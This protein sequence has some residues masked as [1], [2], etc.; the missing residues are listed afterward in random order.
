MTDKINADEGVVD[1]LM[2]RVE[3]CSDGEF[4][5]LIEDWFGQE[6]L[7]DDLRE[8]VSYT[9]NETVKDL[10]ERMKAGEFKPKK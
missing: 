9:D 2:A 10:L 8:S 3:K 1:E 5:N 6:K 4:M 7:M